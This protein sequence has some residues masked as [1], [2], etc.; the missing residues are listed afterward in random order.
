MVTDPAEVKQGLWTPLSCSATVTIVHTEHLTHADPP[1]FDR[2]D[3]DKNG[4]IDSKEL[5]LLAASLGEMWDDQE[6]TAAMKHIDT[7]GDKAI[8]FDVRNIIRVSHLYDTGTMI[9]YLT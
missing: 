2:F 7:S 8:S 3:T 9:R 5:A 6:V 4:G 1:V